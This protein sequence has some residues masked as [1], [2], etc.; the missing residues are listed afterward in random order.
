MLTE[1]GLTAVPAVIP[2]ASSTTTAVRHAIRNSGCPRC[3]QRNRRTPTLCLKPPTYEG[4]PVKNYLLIISCSHRKRTTPGTLAALDRY[5][6]PTYRTL[7]KARHEGRVPEKLDVLIISAR[8]GIF[9]CQQ[10]IGDYD[11]CMTPKRATELRPRIQSQLKSILVT[12]R[13]YDQV[14][15]NLGK[16]YRQTLDGFHWG[17]LST[18]EATGGIGQKTSQMKAWLAQN[19]HQVSARGLRPLSAVGRA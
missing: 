19:S 1:A 18:L 13:G 7:R 2:C 8:Y 12:S 14:F 9:P 15:I 16:V 3:S 6:G 5:D 10:S 4:C 17:L 11:Q